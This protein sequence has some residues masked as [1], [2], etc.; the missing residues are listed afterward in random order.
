MVGAGANRIGASAS[1]EI[2]ASA[3]AHA[4]LMGKL[5]W[6]ETF[7]YKAERPRR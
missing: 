1:A 5:V 7:D 2:L 3:D 4:E 6:D